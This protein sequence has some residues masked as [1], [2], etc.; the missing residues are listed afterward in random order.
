[1]VWQ[2]FRAS[3]AR[4]EKRLAAPGRRSSRQPAGRPLGAL[5]DRVADHR[6]GRTIGDYC[7]F[8]PCACCG[9]EETVNQHFPQSLPP[10]THRQWPFP[11]FRACDMKVKP[12]TG[13]VS[14]TRPVATAPAD[15]SESL[16]GHAQP[17]RLGEASFRPLVW[18]ARV[19]FRI[20]RGHLGVDRLAPAV[21]HLAQLGGLRRA[22]LRPDRGSRRSRPSGC[23]TRRACL[24]R[25][26]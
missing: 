2:W 18:L 25:T 22:C 12:P 13:R 3:D 5:P 8:G 11:S 4:T 20:G 10:T 1:M 21:Q 7:V 19:I 15:A 14:Q 6:D 9:G 23:T 16:L 26:R 17:G 24:R